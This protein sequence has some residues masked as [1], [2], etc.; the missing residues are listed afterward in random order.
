MGNITTPGEDEE[1][2]DLEQLVEAGVQEPLELVH[3]VVEH[4][5]D[6]AQPVLLEEGDL[7]RLDAVVGVHPQVVLDGAGRGS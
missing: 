5:E 3:V 2:G 4:G 1:H 7:A 6:L